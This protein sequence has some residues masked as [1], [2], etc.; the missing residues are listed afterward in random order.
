MVRKFQHLVAMGELKPNDIIIHYFWKDEDKAYSK[1]INILP[2]GQ[3]SESFEKGFYDES[4]NIALD[5]FKLQNYQ[6]N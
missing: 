3:L 2:N 5:I 6:N 1:Q 4:D